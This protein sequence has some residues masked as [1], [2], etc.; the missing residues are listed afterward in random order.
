M[1]PV[2]VCF[3]IIPGCPNIAVWSLSVPLVPHVET[4]C[5]TLAK[6]VNYELGE[7]SLESLELGKP[8]SLAHFPSVPANKGTEILIHLTRMQELKQVNLHKAF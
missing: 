5:G 4:K 7:S 3:L 2:F 6:G 1:M 8:F